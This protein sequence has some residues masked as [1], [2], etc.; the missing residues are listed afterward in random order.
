[1]S[2]IYK[3]LKRGTEYRIICFALRKSDKEKMVV[4]K[5]IYDSVIWVRP[6]TEFNE[7]FKEVV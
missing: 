5:H 1:M 4:Y 7:K 2:K 6:L 3:H